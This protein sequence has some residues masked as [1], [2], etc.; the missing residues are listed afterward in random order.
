MKIKVV[1]AMIVEE[2]V[3]INDPV[4]IKF[5]NTEAPSQALVTCACEA[6]GECVGLPFGEENTTYEQPNYICAVYDAESDKILL[7]Y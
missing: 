5:V 3:E 4:F 7:E 6:V 2:E 1:K